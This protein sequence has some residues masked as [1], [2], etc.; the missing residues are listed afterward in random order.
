MRADGYLSL[1]GA[2]VS[3]R[4]DERELANFQSKFNAARIQYVEPKILVTGGYLVIRLF[5]TARK[6]LYSVVD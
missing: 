5:V 4:L 1:F 6:E 3:L 2:N